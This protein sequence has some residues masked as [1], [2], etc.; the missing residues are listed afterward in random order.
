MAA[1]VAKPERNLVFPGSLTE[2]GRMAE[3]LRQYQEFA[4]SEL[5][6]FAHQAASPERPPADALRTPH[7]G[8]DDR[9]ATSPRGRQRKARQ[10]AAKAG[11]RAQAGRHAEALGTLREAAR[12]DPSNAE[13]LHDLGRACISAGHSS[14]AAAALRRAIALQPDR[15]GTRLDLA[16]A[17]DCMGEAQAAIQAYKKAVELQPDQVD[18]LERLAELQLNWGSRA[19]AVAA[20]R[21]TAAQMPDSDAAHVNAARAFLLDGASAES[22]RLLRDVIA[23]QPGNCAALMTMARLL[24]DKGELDA[25]SAGYERAAML[26]P[27]LAVAWYGCAANRR[28]TEADRPLIARILASLQR[29]NRLPDHRMALHFALGKV[30]DDLGEYAVAIRH[31]DAANQIDVKGRRL[32]RGGLAGR[33]DELIAASPPGFLI[34]RPD[35]AQPGELPILIVGMPRSGTTL[36]EQILSS[37][38]AV[39]AG[40]EL[41]YW[42]DLRRGPLGG[43]ESAAVA[44]RLAGDYLTRLS[45]ISADAARVTDKMPFNYEQ[46]GLIRQVLPR[47]FIVHCRRHPVDTCLSIYTTHFR[48]RLAD[49]GD[50]VFQYRQYARLLAHWRSV[51]PAGRFFEIDY[52]TLVADPEHATRQ[53]I[54]FCG[55]EWDDACLAPHRNRRSVATASLWQARQPIYQRSVARW[56]HYEP[57]LGE[58]R[59]L[60]PPAGLAAPPA[61]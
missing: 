54:A 14:E 60:L 43:N 31:F 33:T 19:E 55:L 25:A 7:A 23:R 50:L 39:A 29:P 36:V 2:A 35:F 51:L 52:E 32:D 42:P 21:A 26:N 5:E 34:S 37:H 57:W 56:R 41:T 10:L 53:L 30:H 38:P 22:E 48:A 49:R 47:A 4:P 59:D 61:G 18:A 8:D 20:F 6:L 11:R 28:F 3:D 45:G 17:L 27:S 40:G 16:R 46:L 1:S 12:L 9:A 58:L 44:G 15:A 13:L 24:A